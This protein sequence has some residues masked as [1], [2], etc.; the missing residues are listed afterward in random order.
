MKR[1]KG[2]GKMEQVKEG[3]RSKM[4]KR[5]GKDETRVKERIKEREMSEKERTQLGK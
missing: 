2:K 1:V 4:S 5:K 3:M